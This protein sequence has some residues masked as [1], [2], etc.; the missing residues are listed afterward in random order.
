MLEANVPHQHSHMVVENT[1]VVQT[2][3]VGVDVL[4]QSLL[5]IAF[6]MSQIVFGSIHKILVFTKLCKG[7]VRLK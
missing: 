6:K 3:A 1:V 5:Q 2:V 4:L 7:Q